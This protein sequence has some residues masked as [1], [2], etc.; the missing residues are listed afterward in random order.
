MKLIYSLSFCLGLLLT[1]AS[2]GGGKD[3][4][5]P[6]QRPA[7]TVRV[8]ESKQEAVTFYDEFPATVVALDEVE[9]RPQT[10]GYITQVYFREGDL[11]RKGQRL[12][13][14]DVRRYA[15][16]VD[17][18][19]STV[20]SAQAN[21]DLAE[22]NVERYR[23]LAEAEAIALQTLDQAEAEVEARRQALESANAGV[24]SARTQ[25]DYTVIRAPLS[26]VTSL[27]SAKSG[28]Q[29]SPGQPLLT[30]IS[31]EAPIGVDFALP[32]TQ[33]P[34]LSRM[35][36]TGIDPRDSVFRLRLPDGSLYA[37]KGKIYASD[38]VVD[39]RTGSL[40]VRLEFTNQD[41]VLRPG[42][43]LEIEM[44]NDQSGRQVLIPTQALSEQMGE[45]YVM[46]V[47]DSVTY[48]Q[49]VTTG[50]QLGQQVVVTEGLDAGKIV[51]IE[52]LKSVKDS[53]KVQI[54]PPRQE[55]NKSANQ[56]QNQG[57]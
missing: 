10:T 52:G 19:T 37:G 31:K 49:K 1:C 41:K 35:E 13:T 51:V 57:E 45:F 39:P 48:R 47:R 21:L 56:A 30:T 34:R 26:G 42:M 38:R 5:A 36:K 14:V 11:V 12:Y 27:N 9:V 53:T 7:P 18:A 22:K 15:A 24:R 17:Q 50:K 20:A 8:A 2:C 16:D 43:T 54:A 28:T 29:V 44:L 25:L 3:E 6:Q 23:R 32:Q 40:N 33:I 46:E 55:E 4:E